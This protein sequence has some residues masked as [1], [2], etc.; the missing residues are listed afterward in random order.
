MTPSQREELKEG[1]PLIH[2]LK[3]GDKNFMAFSETEHK[4]LSLW[5]GRTHCS[6]AE[7]FYLLQNIQFDTIWDWFLCGALSS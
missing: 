2:V 7:C 1:W 3:E 5:E 4:I 6:G